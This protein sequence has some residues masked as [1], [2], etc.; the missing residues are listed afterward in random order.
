MNKI[1]FSIYDFFGYL[2]CGFL[3]LAAIDFTFNGGALL[4][5]KLD[6]FATVIFFWIMLIYI[7][8][9]LI[10][11]TASFLLE[12]IM[13]RKV[14]GAPEQLL[15]HLHRRRR[16][17][18]RMARIF[19]GYYLPLPAETRERVLAK[20]K[21]RAGIEEP[22]RGLF[23]HSHAIVKREQVTLDRL[24]NFLNALWLLP[25]YE[26]DGADRSGNLAYTRRRLTLA[27]SYGAS[28][29]PLVGGSGCDSR[30]RNVLSLP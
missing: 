2:S 19:P 20:A 12:S 10:A 3:L 7:L 24:N 11:N 4:K 22:G 30:H 6:G 23:F 25:E 16:G 5:Q 18:A 15:F 14:L 27:S 29:E 21:D 13:V 8:G 1:P 17:W 9:H 28:P 26:L